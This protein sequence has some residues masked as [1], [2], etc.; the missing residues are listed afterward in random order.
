MRLL[1]VSH[2]CV[3]PINQ[4]F[5]AEVERETGWELIIVTPSNWENEYGSQI[6]PER[7]HE[8]RGQLVNI[9]VWKS[10]NIPLHLYRS[11][12]IPLLREFEPDAIY[13]HHEP[14]AAATAQVYLAN[15][16]SLRRPIGFYSAQNILKSYP[17]PFRQTEQAIFHS[18]QFAFPV[19][20]SVEQVLHKKGCKEMTTVLP[21]GIDPEVYFPHPQAQKVADNL[22]RS[23]KEILIG[24]LGRISAEKGL[25]TLLY[26]LKQLENL[27]WRLIVVG[28][29]SYEAEFEAIAQNLQLQ[30]RINRLGYVPHVE[31]PLYLSAFDVLVLPSET[32]P[33]WKEQF[34]RVIIEAIACGTPVV[35]SDSGEI[36]YLLQATGGGLTFPEGQPDALAE[37]LKQLIINSS[38]RSQLVGQSRPIVLQNYTN[39]SLA[40]RFAQTIEKAVRDKNRK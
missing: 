16:L 20:Q 24:Y 15:R 18:S 12:F 38:L 26:A 37:K 17:P 9:P 21:L 22:R 3:T 25:K 39:S 5:Y 4:Q 36:P 27:S 29:G 13:V 6:V 19:S 35:G 8:Y 30:A 34:G 32:R 28:S 11:I 1:I 31:A 2:P 7:W 40:Q 14:Y 23:E 33:N 10:G